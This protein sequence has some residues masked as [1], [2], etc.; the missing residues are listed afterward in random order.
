[1]VS[2]QKTVLYFK[3]SHQSAVKE[4]KINSKTSVRISGSST[5][6]PPD[7]YPLKSTTT[8]LPPY[9]SALLADYATEPTG[10]S[11]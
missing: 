9:Y 2:R 11:W 1:M 7:S 10:Q 6:I 5:N 8:K 4:L 3:V